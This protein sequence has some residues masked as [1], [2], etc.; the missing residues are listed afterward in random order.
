MGE[1]LNN[2]TLSGTESREKDILRGLLGTLPVY[3]YPKP[4]CF[5]GSVQAI[6]YSFQALSSEG[7]SFFVIFILSE[8]ETSRRPS[9]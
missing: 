7:L 5:D 8:R 9:T 1:L 3:P 2:R 6:K 4:A